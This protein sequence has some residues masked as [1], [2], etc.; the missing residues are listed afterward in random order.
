MNIAMFISGRGSFFRFALANQNMIPNARFKCIVT[1]KSGEEVADISREYDIPVIPITYKGRERKDIDL[2]ILSLLQKHR[3][4]TLV[5]NYNK[6]LGPG[7]ITA[8][9]NIF[10]LHL[11]LLPL[12]K[13]FGAIEAA[14][15]ANDA[16]Y[17]ATIHRVDESTDGGE[18]VAQTSIARRTSATLNEV[19][20]DIFRYGCLLQLDTIHGLTENKSEKIASFEAASFSPPL[21]IDA[22]TAERNYHAKQSFKLAV[23]T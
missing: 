12:H 23:N 3:I 1:D 10:N 13:G 15:R 4:E 5:L 22:A 11:S 6:L 19:T 16:R 20:E 14:Y 2:E 9:K 8:Y 18:I 17:G 21:S 7:L